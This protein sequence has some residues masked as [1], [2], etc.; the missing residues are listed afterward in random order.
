VNWEEVAGDLIRHLHDEVS[1]TP[2]DA[3]AQALLDEV[4]QYPGV[5]ACWQRRDI[6]AAPPPLLT[7]EFCKDGRTLRFF[8]ALTTFG[9]SRVVTIDDLRIEC[10]SP[11]DAATADLCRE[12][13]GSCGTP[14][15]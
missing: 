7:V 5:P 3:E 2:T 4:L 6:G 14:S 8:S 15:A 12:L 11:A 1:A 10:N 9:T 13:A